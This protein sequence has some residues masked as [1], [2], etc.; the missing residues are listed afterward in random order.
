[1]KTLEEHN[2]DKAEAFMRNENDK[3]KTGI[4]CP[5]CKKE[6]IRTYPGVYLSSWPEQ[7]NVH[8][9]NCKYVGYAAV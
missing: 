9:G 2:R 6:L 8:C 4:E 7:I 5:N 1:M 3:Y